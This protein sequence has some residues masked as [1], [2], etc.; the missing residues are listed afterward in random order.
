LLCFYDLQGIAWHY[1]QKTP[2]ASGQDREYRIAREWSRQWSASHQAASPERICAR[3][4]ADLSEAN[5]VTTPL[6]VPEKQQLRFHPFVQIAVQ[7]AWSQF[8]CAQK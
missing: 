2:Q 1:V 5:A 4:V 3:R 6:P 7:N 8:L